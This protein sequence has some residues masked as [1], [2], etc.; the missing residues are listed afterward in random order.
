MNRLSQIKND[1]IPISAEFDIS[2]F[3]FP[4]G[5]TESRIRDG[6][7]KKRVLFNLVII[8]LKYGNISIIPEATVSSF[9]VPC[10]QDVN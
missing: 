9:S 10:S 8:D 5:F 3:F 6:T 2:L 1:Y 4:F 7:S